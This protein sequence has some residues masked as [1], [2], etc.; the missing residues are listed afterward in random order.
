MMGCGACRSSRCAAIATAV[1]AIRCASRAAMWSRPTQIRPTR[2]PARWAAA[3]RSASRWRAVA[4][5]QPAT[6]GSLAMSAAGCGARRTAAV[7]AS[8]PPNV[9]SNPDRDLPGLT[10]RNVGVPPWADVGGAGVIAVHH[11]DRDAAA[12]L[13]DADAH[14]ARFFASVFAEPHAIVAPQARALGALVRR[15]ISRIDGAAALAVFDQKPRRRPRIERRDVIVDVAAERGAD[16]LRLAQGE[17]IALADVVQVAQLDHQM[18]DAV[19]AG[20]DEGKAVVARIDVEEIR[21]E[22]FENVVAGLEVQNVG[23][24][25]HHFVEPL[26]G[27]N[28]MAHAERAGAEA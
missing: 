22:R 8:G 3:A 17:I 6:G 16:H 24:E 13:G 23:V 11:V 27:E 18:M 12:G 15:P 2:W 19:L 7:P 5:A 9:A 25:W 14:A 21:L 1:I 10:R 20:I 26:G 28:G 4:R